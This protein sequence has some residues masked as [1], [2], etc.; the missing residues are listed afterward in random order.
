VHSTVTGLIL[1]SKLHYFAQS[2]TVQICTSPLETTWLSSLYLT[3]WTY[4]FDSYSLEILLD[5]GKETFFP[6]CILWMSSQRMRRIIFPELGQLMSRRRGGGVNRRRAKTALEGI[7]Q[8]LQL[9]DTGCFKPGQLEIMIKCACDRQDTWGGLPCGRVPGRLSSS[10]SDL[11]SIE[12]YDWVSQSLRRFGRD[13][14]TQRESLFSRTL[15]QFYWCQVRGGDS[16]PE[17][18]EMHRSKLH[19]CVQR[20]IIQ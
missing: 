17:S 10:S 12:V 5:F 7:K 3:S 4:I 9:D 6:H 1:R 16:C 20:P 8:M 19:S 11:T 15:L 13:S 14:D 18:A 2:V